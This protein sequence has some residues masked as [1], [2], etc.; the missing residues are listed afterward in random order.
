MRKPGAL[1]L[2]SMTQ[3]M[4]QLVSEEQEK[5]LMRSFN[6]EDLVKSQDGKSVLQM[7]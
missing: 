2:N 5:D 1:S 7:N 4:T 3:I 6:Q